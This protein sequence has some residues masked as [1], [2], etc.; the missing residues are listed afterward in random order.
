MQSPIPAWHGGWKHPH[1][2]GS[3]GNFPFFCVNIPVRNLKCDGASACVKEQ[4]IYTLWLVRADIEQRK[5][6][7]EGMRPKKHE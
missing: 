4:L 7:T 2:K 3:L 5:R 6:F 1:V